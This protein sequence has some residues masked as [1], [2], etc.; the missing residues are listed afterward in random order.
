MFYYCTVEHQ[1]CYI[2]TRSQ[3]VLHILLFNIKHQ[4]QTKYFPT[5]LCTVKVICDGPR[6]NF[7]YKGL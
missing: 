4:M 3:Y 7:L 1:L 2:L 5:L 6:L